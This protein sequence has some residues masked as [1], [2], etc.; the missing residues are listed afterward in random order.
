MGGVKKEEPEKEREIF[1]QFEAAACHGLLLSR[2]ELSNNALLFS[3][4]KAG[5]Q[6]SPVLTW[7]SHQL[8]PSQR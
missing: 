5:V 1:S 3:E 2:R 4:G 6:I 7:I 8:S